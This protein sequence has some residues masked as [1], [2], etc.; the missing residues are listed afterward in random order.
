MTLKNNG[1]IKVYTE[2]NESTHE[3]ALGKVLLSDHITKEDVERGKIEFKLRMWV[4]EDVKINETN[5]DNYNN[6]KFGVRVNTYA[7]FEG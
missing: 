6:R 4:S 7:Q 3:E 1:K 2:Y 5:M